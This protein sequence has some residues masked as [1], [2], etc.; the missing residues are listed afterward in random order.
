[1]LATHKHIYTHAYTDTHAQA[2]TQA[3]MQA[4]T[5]YMHSPLS[6]S[7]HPHTLALESQT[8]ASSENVW[9]SSSEE[10]R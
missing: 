2:F 7:L 10:K 9:P 5:M 6:L 3:H 4:Y 8:L 1:M